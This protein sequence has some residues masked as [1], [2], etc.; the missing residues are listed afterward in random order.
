MLLCS[1]MSLYF[2]FLYYCKMHLLK[3]FKSSKGVRL[4][5][6]IFEKRSADFVLVKQ[7]FDFFTVYSWQ[8]K[9][10]ITNYSRSNVSSWKTEHSSNDRIST[11]DSNEYHPGFNFWLRLLRIKVDSWF[12]CFYCLFF[13]FDLLLLVFLHFFKTRTVS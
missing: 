5:K 7:P 6:G 10:G 1:L 8:C 13:L 2:V 9:G 4:S 3:I 11:M 12:R